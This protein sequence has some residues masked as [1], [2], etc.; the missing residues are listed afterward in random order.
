VIPLRFLL[1]YQ[2]PI[3]RDPGAR[4]ERGSQQ[5]EQATGYRQLAAAMDLRVRQLAG[6]GVPRSEDAETFV[7]TASG[8][9]RKEEAQHRAD[10][11]D[12]AGERGLPMG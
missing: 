2:L 12:C 1:P 3:R 5:T 9:R 4:T 11:C 10:Y 8:S 7:R 6:E